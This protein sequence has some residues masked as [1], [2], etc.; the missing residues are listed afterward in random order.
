MRRRRFWSLCLLLT[1]CAGPGPRPE[2]AD[3]ATLPTSELSTEEQR[4]LAQAVERA[5]QAVVQRQYDVARSNAL[6][7]LALDA[8]CARARAVLGMVMLQEASLTDPPDLAVSQQAER[9][10]VLAEQLAPD[11]MFVGWMHAVFLAEAGHM[12]AAAATAE[13]ALARVAANTP[14]G[15]R[16]ALFGIA[17]TYR[18][19]LGEERAALPHLRT[20]LSLRP[21]DATAFF[22]LGSCLLRIAAVPQGLRAIEDA[23][24][25]AADAARAFERCVELAPGDEDASL[26]IAT[27]WWRAAE[28][29][30]ELGSGDREQLVAAARARLRETAERFPSSAEAWFRL[31]VIAEGTEA[32]ADAGTCYREALQRNARHIGALLNLAHLLDAQGDQGAAT[33]LLQQVLLTDAALDCLSPDERARVR[34]RVGGAATQMP[35]ML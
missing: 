6:A 22:R 21:D 4:A 23:K 31:G 34:D 7:C 3:A 20:Y 11:D 14:L 17:A 28:L 2:R 10:L 9:E 25:N 15:E 26:A 24:T 27:A 30:K 8:R 19:E 35:R 12:S 16:A 5:M 32:S 18:Y 13:R 33:T 1:A 29:A